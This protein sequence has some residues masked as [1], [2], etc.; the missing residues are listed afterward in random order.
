MTN[1][2]FKK[3]LKDETPRRCKGALGSVQSWAMWLAWKAYP[4]KDA[5]AP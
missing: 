1:K 3:L 2:K 4:Y 5:N